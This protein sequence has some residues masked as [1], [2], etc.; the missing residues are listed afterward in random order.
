MGVEKRLMDSRKYPDLS[1]LIREALEQDREVELSHGEYGFN[2]VV[3]D[4]E[5]TTESGE[6]VLVPELFSGLPLY[7]KKGRKNGFV[8]NLTE[9]A[10]DKI[11]EVDSDIENNTTGE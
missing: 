7:W 8:S 3:D 6:G 5:I 4:V 9:E 2:I 11:R 1:H 10:K